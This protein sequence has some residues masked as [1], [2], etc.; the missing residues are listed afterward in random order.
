MKS[1]TTVLEDWLVAQGMHDR[2]VGA[3]KVVGMGAGMLEGTAHPLAAQAGENREPMG[4][5]RAGAAKAP[6]SQQEVGKRQVKLG[7][8]GDSFLWLIADNVDVVPT[9]KRAMPAPFPV[10][11][12]GGK[13]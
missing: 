11:I 5:K 12:K 10:C 13:A 6:A 4:M 9:G 7:R 8:S 3:G 1:V 2:T